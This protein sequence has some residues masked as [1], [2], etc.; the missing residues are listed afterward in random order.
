MME[1]ESEG[2]AGVHMRVLGPEHSDGKPVT[3]SLGTQVIEGVP[4]DGVRTTITS[5]FRLARWATIAR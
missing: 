2:G 3:E 4:A 1:F 5:R